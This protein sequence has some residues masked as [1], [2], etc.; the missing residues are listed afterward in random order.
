M[1]PFVILVIPARVVVPVTPRLVPIVVAPERVEVPVT[2]KFPVKFKF[3]YVNV[4]VKF[5]FVIFAVVIFAVPNVL[6]LGTERVPERARFV[7]LNNNVDVVN[8][9]VT[10]KLVIVVLPETPNV[11]DI[12]V[13]PNVS[14]IKL[15]ELT[16]IPPFK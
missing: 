14:T 2:P 3:V 8:V 13:S 12:V 9:P 5:R 16:F 6:V 7:V 4:P 15:P 11:P 10:F 1:V